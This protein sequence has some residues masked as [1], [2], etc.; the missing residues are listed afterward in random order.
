MPISYDW[1]RDLVEI[2]ADL[3]AFIRA[4]KVYAQR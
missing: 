3:D 4:K 1:R 2:A